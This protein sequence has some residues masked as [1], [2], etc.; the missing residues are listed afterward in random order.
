MAPVRIDRAHEVQVRRH[1][2]PPFLGKAFGGRTGLVYV[3]IVRALNGHATY[4]FAHLRVT[5]L[6]PAVASCGVAALNDHRQG[7]S[8]AKVKYLLGLDSKLLEGADR[9]R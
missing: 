5:P 4:P 2:L 8:A 7:D 6:D 3:A 1:R 9:L